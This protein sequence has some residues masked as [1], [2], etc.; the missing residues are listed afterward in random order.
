MMMR[1]SLPPLQRSIMDAKTTNKSESEFRYSDGSVVVDPRDVAYYESVRDGEQAWKTTPKGIKH[2]AK[3]EPDED[4]DDKKNKNIDAAP[5]VVVPRTMT[6]AEADKI[7]DAA[8]KQMCD[9]LYG[10]KA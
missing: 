4:D 5:Q 2:A 1:D 3:L 10:R 9:E 7:K 6:H 8:Y